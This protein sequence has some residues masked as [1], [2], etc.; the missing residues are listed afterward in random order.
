M[1]R[2]ELYPMERILRHDPITGVPVMQITSQPAMSWPLHYE[3]TT[4]TRDAERMLVLRAR[5]SRR[6]APTDLFTCRVDGSDLMQLNVGDTEAG[7][8]GACLSVEGE[9]ALYFEDGALHRTRLDNGEDEELGGVEGAQVG[10]TNGMR[11]Y[12]GKYYFGYA[13]IDDDRSWMLRWDLRTGETTLVSE[14]QSFNHL[15]ANPGGTEIGFNLAFDLPERGKFKRVFKTVHCETLEEME[16]FYPFVHFPHGKYGTAH[17]FWHGT[18]NRYQGTLQ[19]PGHGIVLMDRGAEE[20]ELIATGP[21]FWHSGSSYDGEW[22]VADT[23]FPDEGLWLINTK[24][25]RK[26]LI[27][28]PNASQGDSGH[29]HPHPNLSDDGRLICFRSDATGISQAY[30]VEVPEEIREDLSAPSEN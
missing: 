24:T 12:D 21:Y 7:I 11:S 2:G 26:Q 1:P 8:S 27:C 16:D 3:T 29:G 17:S 25:R 5:G 4:F 22:I 28:Y 14:S 20:P 23:A 15:S 19:W 6:G 18:T 10:G 9:H 30:V 13:R